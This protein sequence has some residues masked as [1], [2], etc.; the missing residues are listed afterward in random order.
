M[1][2][3][4]Y[5]LFENYTCIISKNQWK[6]TGYLVTQVPLENSVETHW[7]VSEIP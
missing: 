5:Y 2:D 7:K 3:R 1:F 4:F 6:V